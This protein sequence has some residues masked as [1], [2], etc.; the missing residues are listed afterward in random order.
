MSHPRLPRI[1]WANDARDVAAVYASFD[2]L[3]GLVD[4][5]LSASVYRE[6]WSSPLSFDA[7]S[8][9][10][11]FIRLLGEP[12]PPAIDRTSWGEPSSAWRNSDDSRLPH[13]S[14][15]TLRS[16]DEDDVECAA[17]DAAVELL[18]ADQR[19][20]DALTPGSRV[21]PAQ[22][23]RAIDQLVRATLRA[24][25]MRAHAPR[26]EQY[27]RALFTPRLPDPVFL[28]PTLRAENWYR[29]AM[30]GA[31]DGLIA[32]FD[33]WLVEPYYLG[34][35]VYEFIAGVKKA[36]RRPLPPR[37]FDGGEYADRYYIGDD[38]SDDDDVSEGVRQEHDTDAYAATRG[39]AQSIVR[40]QL[41]ECGRAYEDAGGEDM[42][43][44]PTDRVASRAVGL[45][46][47]AVTRAARAARVVQ[48][49]RMEK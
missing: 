47:R 6:K 24:A 19:L 37:T 3:L 28:V 5:R 17:Y 36:F 20:S 26:M 44:F 45:T 48:P 8:L 30:F 29:G 14:F 23:R 13:P 46:I 32:G 4:E 41:Q 2:V 16:D 42:E 18:V 35:W 27:E 40:A 34:E 7:D 31:Y 11:S 10:R 22:R 49:K 12:L 38:E 39:L 1:D 21:A 33:E 25:V 43:N 15:E 9:E